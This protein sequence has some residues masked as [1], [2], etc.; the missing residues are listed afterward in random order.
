MDTN[1]TRFE[2][3]EAINTERAYQDKKWG[4]AGVSSIDEF[5]LYI[6]GYTAD[7]VKETSHN[8]TGT[9]ALNIIRKIAALGV[10][11]MEHHGAP[12]RRTPLDDI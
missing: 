4:A 10:A 1:R 11:C 6:A 2:V 8:L 12:K 7:L 3:Y 9:E 5:S